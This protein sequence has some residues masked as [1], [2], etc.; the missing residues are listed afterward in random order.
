M[1]HSCQVQ[2]LADVGSIHYFMGTLHGKSFVRAADAEIIVHMSRN[3]GVER[4][5]NGG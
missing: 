2:A 3:E 1:L 5:A 4:W